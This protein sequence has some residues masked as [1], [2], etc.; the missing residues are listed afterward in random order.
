MIARLTDPCKRVMEAPWTREPIEFRTLGLFTK[1]RPTSETVAWSSV[2]CLVHGVP[3]GFCFLFCLTERTV[4]FGTVFWVLDGSCRCG[5]CTAS[6]SVATETCSAPRDL[7]F[8]ESRKLK[9]KPKT[10][11]ESAIRNDMW[12]DAFPLTRNPCWTWEYSQLI[13]A[14]E[15]EPV[16]QCDAL[17]NEALNMQQT[18]TI[19]PWELSPVALCRTRPFLRTSEFLMRRPVLSVRH[20]PCG[21]VRG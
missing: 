6:G 12:N 16:G 4:S 14:F 21:Y 19:A 15:A 9:E 8:Q 20:D 10:A 11:D 5:I 2:A 18:W 1:V 7:L 13:Q 17:G 3:L